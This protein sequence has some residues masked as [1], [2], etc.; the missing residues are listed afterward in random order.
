[1]DESKNSAQ[2]SFDVIDCVVLAVML[3]ISAVV[4]VYQAY[5]AKKNTDAVREYLVGGQNMPIIPISMSL[6]A[7]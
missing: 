6:I 7:R 3:G 2:T 1:M 5:K 4:G